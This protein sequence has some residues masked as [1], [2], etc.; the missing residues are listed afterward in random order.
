MP[1]DSRYTQNDEGWKPSLDPNKAQAKSGQGPIFS[2]SRNPK[3]PQQ[4][5]S[6]P[7]TPVHAEDNDADAQMPIEF[8]SDETQ[9]GI[10]LNAY[11]P[12]L[13][14]QHVQ[15]GYQTPGMPEVAQPTPY[16][17]NQPGQQPF[18]AHGRGDVAR[19]AR[20]SNID[21]VP[22]GPP[23]SKIATL[24]KKDPAYRVLFVAIGVV[25]LCSLGGSLLLVSAVGHS[26]QA[27]QQ[28]NSNVSSVSTSNTPTVPTPDPNKQL[29]ATTQAATATALAVTPTQQPMPTPTPTQP[30]PTPTQPTP[31][32]PPTLNNNG[33]LSVQINNLPGSADNHSTVPVTVTANHPGTIVRLVVSYSG[34]QPSSY[35]SGSQSVDANGNTTIYW[36]ID[37]QRSRFFGNT[38]IARVM[39]VAQDQNGNVNNSSIGSVQINMGN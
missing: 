15:P 17:Q 36:N 34:A 24:W 18:Y 31:T 10:P 7:Q 1:G 20:Y 9:A 19:F 12:T 33:P 6:P 4:P 25:L 38:V 2:Q 28:A 11:P 16:Q 23:H 8:F 29:Q 26:G 21:P 37:E 39:A 22:P 30:T 27:G 14:S 35:A 32:P 5:P 13:P 3:H